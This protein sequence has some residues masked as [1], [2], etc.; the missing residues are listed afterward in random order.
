MTP[1]R[2]LGISVPTPALF[3]AIDDLAMKI[4]S[5]AVPQWVELFKSAPLRRLTLEVN[6]CGDNWSPGR[7]TLTALS[8]FVHSEALHL[9]FSGYLVVLNYELKAFHYLKNLRSLRL[10]PDYGTPRKTTSRM[11]MWT[12]SC[13]I[14]H[15]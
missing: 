3:S 8:R 15:S 12:N 4:L 14:C 2:L 13:L 5:P 9:Y 6:H 10:Q 1:S 11:M 7:A